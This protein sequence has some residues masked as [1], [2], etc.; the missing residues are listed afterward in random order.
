MSSWAQIAVALIT[1]SGYIAVALITTRRK[2]PGD[3]DGQ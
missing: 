2:P 1:T 3:D